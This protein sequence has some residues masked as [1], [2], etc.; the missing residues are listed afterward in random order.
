MRTS[1][2][3]L[4]SKWPVE[5]MKS[6]MHEIGREISCL[7]VG[8]SAPSASE[9]LSRKLHNASNCAPENETTASVTYALAIAFSSRT[10]MTPSAWD[11]DSASDTSNNA[12]Q[13]ERVG[14]GAR[15]LGM[16]LRTRPKHSSLKSSKAVSDGP[17]PC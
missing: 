13:G 16:C 3:S 10:S 5:L 12:Y 8:P 17:S 15:A 14:I 4:A 7:I 6:E 11:S 2:Y 1:G 9:I